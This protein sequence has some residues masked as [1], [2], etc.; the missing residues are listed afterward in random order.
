M[1]SLQPRAASL[2]ELKIIACTCE[3]ILNSCVWH[4][5]IAECAGCETLAW[6][7][8]ALASYADSATL[9]DHLGMTK[10]LKEPFGVF[11][12]TVSL[13]AGFPAMK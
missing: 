2:N 10:S 3:C 5:Q 1:P 11:W 6:F 4:A 12:F 9:G 8:D 13:R 7:L